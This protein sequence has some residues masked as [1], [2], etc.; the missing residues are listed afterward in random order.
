MPRKPRDYAAEY[1][2]RNEL[3]K[4]R[5]HTNY[6][7]QRRKIERGQIRAIAP[8]R[9]RSRKT[10]EAQDAVYGLFGTQQLDKDTERWLSTVDVQ[11]VR[12]DMAQRWSDWYSRHWSTEFDAKRAAKDEHYLTVYMQGFVLSQDKDK[13]AHHFDGSRWQ[14]EWFV[15]ITGYLEADDYADRYGDST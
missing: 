1:R 15:D 12:I 13:N 11:D 10:I 9:L 7:Q 8:T 2:R 14:H 5:G 6:A 4:Q 3:A